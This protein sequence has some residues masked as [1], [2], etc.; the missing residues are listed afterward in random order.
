[1][2][3]NLNTTTPKKLLAEF[4]KAIDE[5]H[6]VT[7]SYNANG[8][9]THDVD[10]WRGEALMRPVI[11]EGTRLTFNFLRRKTDKTSRELYAI[12]HGRLAESFL[13]HLDTVFDD[14]SA[15]ALG[16]VGD[17]MAVAA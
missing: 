17:R 10:Q 4:K 3:L 11:V 5:G 14:V 12:Y 8:D 1:M 13:A 9:F 2:A 16:T 6:V 15:T 7:W